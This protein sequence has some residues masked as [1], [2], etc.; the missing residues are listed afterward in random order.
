MHLISFSLDLLVTIFYKLYSVYQQT[1][2][3]ELIYQ[4]P[5]KEWFIGLG[6]KY[7]V[8]PWIFG[9]I[10]VGA[11]P[12]FSLSVAWIIRNYRNDKPIILPVFFA[13]LFFI[14]AYLYLIVAGRNVPLWVYGIVISMIIYGV[15]STITKIK[16]KIRNTDEI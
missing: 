9:T 14:S 7:N 3:A 15:Y 11:I 2:I 16:K 5:I 12:F 6:E 1:G 8:N 13:L 4:S 10:Y